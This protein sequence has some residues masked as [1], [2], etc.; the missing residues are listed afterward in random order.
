M[1]AN[2]IKFTTPD[3]NQINLNKQ[4][5]CILIAIDF[6]KNERPWGKLL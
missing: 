4:G 1:N 6:W 2:E 3:A 5:V